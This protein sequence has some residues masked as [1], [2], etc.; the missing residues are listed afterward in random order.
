MPELAEVG[1]FRKRW[2]VGIGDRV[3]RVHLHADKRVFRN[4][5]LPA[6]QSQLVGA[7]LLRSEAHGKQMLFSFSKNIRLGIH[8]GMTGKLSV[9]PPDMEPGKHDHLILFQKLRA[10]VF[11]DSR[12]FGRVF[13]HEGPTKPEWWAKIPAA[14]HSEDFTETKLKEFLLRHP[15]LQLK[16]TLLLQSGFPGVGNW[17]ADEILWRA[18]IS[19]R[20]LG[21]TLS[22]ARRR[23]LWK[24]IRYVCQEALR[25]VGN[26]F[27]DPPQGWLFHERWSRNGRCPIHKIPLRRAVVGGRTSAWCGQCQK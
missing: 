10:L 15:R 1:Y 9:A 14:L 27:S 17:M 11:T 21:P 3:I 16:G 13:Y 19:P 18:G 25:I 26:D 2:D 24:E 6:L 5:N 7:K 4:T 12:Q 20:T 22:P 8:L 23:R